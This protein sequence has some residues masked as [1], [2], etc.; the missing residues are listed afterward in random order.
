MMKCVNSQTKSSARNVLVG[1][2]GN[3]KMEAGAVVTI[4]VSFSGTNRPMMVKSAIEMMSAPGM[5]RTTR[6]GVSRMPRNVSNTAGLFSEP[7][8]I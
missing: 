7:I 8:A 5:R 4:L 2:F 3:A 1:H 6:I